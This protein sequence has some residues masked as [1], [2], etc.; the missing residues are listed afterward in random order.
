MACTAVNPARTA[1][2]HRKNT[3]NA[4]MIL[5]RGHRST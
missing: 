4:A 2:N 5:R 1:V 3:C